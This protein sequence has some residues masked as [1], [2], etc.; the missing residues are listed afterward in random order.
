MPYSMTLTYKDEDS[1]IHKI[2]VSCKLAWLSGV[3][4]LSLIFDN[5]IYLLLLFLSTLPI[6]TLAKI[7]SRWL[8]FMK[9]TLLLCPIIILINILFSNVGEHVVYRVPLQIPFIGYLAITLE[10]I[11]FGVAMS[12]RLCVIMSA[13][14][15]LTF[16]IH[17][18]DLMLQMIKLKVPYRSVMVVSLSTRFFPTLLRD[19]DI[20]MD[21][22][23]SRGVELD[24]EGV[25]RKIRNRMPILIALL[26][27][28]LERA[29]QIAEA[30]EARAFGSKEK[31]TAYK[32][33]DMS[34]LDYVILAFMFSPLIFGVLIRLLDYG[35]YRYYPAL[36]AVRMDGVE[37]W[38]ILALSL[39]LFSLAF[40]SI[41]Y[42]G[43]R[44]FD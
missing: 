38:V 37:P 32:K 7:F 36:Q 19:V 24:K 2:N 13:F 5:P 20:L 10:S 42:R 11:F 21:V 25:M 29:I 6:V 14:T 27:N 22:Q 43:I 1:A 4:I 23:R 15:I 41:L 31:R 8:S 30:M 40:S 35:S 18:D 28:S 44:Q 34:K 39:L 16:T 12:L 9:F 17:P 26:S 33:I 3:M